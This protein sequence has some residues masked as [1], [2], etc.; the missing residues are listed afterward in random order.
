MT[1]HKECSDLRAAMSTANE[2][3]CNYLG[4]ITCNFTIG[5]QTEVIDIDNAIDLFYI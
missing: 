5:M 3:C 2:V 4:N 1:A